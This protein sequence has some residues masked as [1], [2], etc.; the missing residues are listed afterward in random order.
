MEVPGAAKLY[1]VPDLGWFA[2]GGG[3]GP[4][5]TRYTLDVRGALVK[6]DSISLQAYGVDS[7]W[8]TLYIVSP[9]KAYY[10][11]RAGTQLIIWNPSEMVVTGSIPLPE[12]ARDG[13]LALYGYA[14]ILRGKSLLFSVGWFDWEENDSVL[15]ETGL[16][17]IDTETDRVAGVE[18]DER[19]GGVTQPVTTASGDTYLASSALAG[20]A[21]RL[22]RLPTK[23]CVLRVQAGET[24]FDGQYLQELDAL[25]GADVSGEPIPAGGNA[26]YLRVF[27]E[28]VATVAADSATY[29]LTGQS[30]WRWVRWDVATHEVK[31]ITSLDVS[32]SDV[33]WFQVDGR[34]YGTE[35][36]ADYSETT[37]IDLTA[38]GGPKRELTAP[39]FLHGVAKIR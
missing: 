7:L 35:T 34:V 16:V 10:P 30:A 21:Y 18:V 15:G 2:I 31:A 1:A 22:G 8:D 5:I 19:C 28:P 38:E 6:G 25:T 9:T 14:P 4:A 13:Y 37:L 27:D 12:T 17:R 23:P 11:D 24:T 3:E 36:T 33:L 39:G 32:T 20:A 29:E 26:L